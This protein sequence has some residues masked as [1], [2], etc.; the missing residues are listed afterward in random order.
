[1]ADRRC[2]ACAKI[3]TSSNPRQRFCDSTC[4]ANGAKRRAK[5]VPEALVTVLPTPDAPEEP[6]QLGGD[7][8]TATLAELVDADRAD[9]ARGRAALALARRIDLGLDTGSALA[10]AVKTLGETIDAATR[11]ARRQE[12]E[13]D[14]V[15]R[16][17]DEKRH[18]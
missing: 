7:V 16:Q 4:R 6:A 10:S 5:G 1:M 2:A 14:R 15:R 8:Y 11:G 17:R 13:L 18:A 9:T 12:T 3:L